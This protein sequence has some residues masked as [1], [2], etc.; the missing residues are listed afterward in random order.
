MAPKRDYPNRRPSRDRGAVAGLLALLLLAPLGQLRADDAAVDAARVEAALTGGLKWLA[1]N[2]IADGDL[3]GSWACDRA[4][5]RPAVASLAG[6]AFLANGDL[7]GDEG[8]GLVVRRAL[9]FV[10]K[11]AN[12][13][14]YLGQGD[15]SGMYIHAICSLFAL[16]CFGMAD[17][18]EIDE[19]LAEWCAKSIAVT[20]EAQAIRR[21]AAA[22]GGWRYT[23]DT[24]ESD[25]SVSS[26]QL[27]VL[28]AARQCGFAVD[29]SVIADGM[30][31][32]NRA[33]LAP[34][35]DAETNEMQ[36]GGFLYRPGVSLEPEA[37]VS[38]VALL[39]KSIFE[40]EPDKKRDAAL[41]Y[42]SS[43]TP[44]WGGHQYG[45][46]FYFSLFYM[47]QGMFQLGGP[48]WLDYRQAVQRVLV[49]HQTGDGRW[50]LPPDNASQ[51]HLA[52]D[53]YPTAMAVLLLSLDKQY[54]PMY[55]RQQPL[56]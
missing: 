27:M 14:G 44:A 16:S 48:A 11:S 30:A 36:P 5:Y 34:Q 33:Y 53:A 17:E 28:H 29:P 50:P 3:A 6:L 10:M 45:G 40:R 18:S 42:L 51:S 39:I 31:Y 20:V 37:A 49:E 46:Y 52:G 41:A 55:Q 38:G 9:D 26:W 25:V 13:R 7:P 12:A 23:P 35:R 1:E 24:S 15:R 8:H 56:Y 32:V 21:S 43:F 19:E 2:Q 22:Q 54:L 4:A 47:T